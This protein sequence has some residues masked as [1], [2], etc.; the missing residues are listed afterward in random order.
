MFITINEA[1]ELECFKNFRV[2]AGEQGLNNRIKKVGIL[3]YEIKELIEKNFEEGE[4]ALSTLLNIKDNIEDL[5]EIVEALISVGVSGLA[6]K[7]IY[8]EHIPSD[9]I[10]LANKNTFPIMMFRNTYFEDI[11]T[12]VMVAIKEKKESKALGLKIDNILYSDLNKMMIKKIAYEIN[13]NFREKNVIVFCKRKNCNES[14]KEVPSP[15]L[16]YDKTLNKFNKIIPYQDGYLIINTFENVDFD[17]VSGIILRRLEVLGFKRQQYI[18][19]ISSLHE[20]LD[21]INDSIKE[22]MYA[23]KHSMTYDQEVSFFSNIGINK[24]LLPLIDNPWVQKYYDEMIIPLLTYDTRNDT[25]LLKTAISYVKNNGDVKETAKELFQH[26]N[27]IRY[28]VDRI[29]K[30]LSKKCD[31]KHFYEELAVAIRIHNIMDRPL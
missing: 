12:D 14:M 10:E 3:D 9:V 13:G 24:I 4:F 25:E 16:E 2:I 11:I 18:I 26:S 7:P 8:F 6:I 21:E 29:S 1:L 23:F 31:I 28:R 15:R 5:Y 22:S 30:V 27:T 19:G 17:E 20:R